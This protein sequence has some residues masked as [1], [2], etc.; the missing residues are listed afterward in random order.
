MKS[1]YKRYKISYDDK[2]Q[3]NKITNGY[4]LTTILDI[5]KDFTNQIIELKNAVGMKLWKQTLN[6]T[7]DFYCT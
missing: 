2:M 1:T 4:L 5:D 7:L 6:K 3:S